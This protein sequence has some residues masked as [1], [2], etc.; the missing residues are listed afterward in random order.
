M[1]SK[2]RR[3]G[4]EIEWVGA[5][6]SMPAY[7]A[8]QGAS[9][10][11]EMLVWMVANGPVVGFAAGKPGTLLA[12]AAG[13][14][15]E[16]M[17]RPSFGPPHRPSRVRVAS[18]ELATV[19]RAGLPPAIAVTCAPTPEID[20][21]LATM[22]EGLSGTGD[23]AP[24]YLSDDVGAD[25][26]AALFR[27]AARLFR[28]SPWSIVPSDQDLFSVTIESLG[29][30]GAALCVI[31]QLGESRALILFSGLDDFE[32]YVAA[33]GAPGGGLPPKLPPH[34]ALNFE[35][36]ADL[37][38]ALRKEIAQHRWEV[39][40]ADGYPWP[41]AVDEDLVPRPLAAGD[42]TIAE[43]LSL[44]LGEALA[45]EAKLRAAWSDG[46]PFARTFRVRTHKGE[47]EVALRTPYEDAPART[48][49]SRELLVRL[50]EIETG[51]EAIDRRNKSKAAPRARRGKR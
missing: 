50:A 3:G 20:L 17:E 40:G 6:A 37:D 48:R 18:P 45:E 5:L 21:V 47:I 29:V 34:F 44:A 46:P 12:D 23:E 26:M 35:R 25:A 38:P 4:H 36:G 51:G 2:K 41:V 16:T 14:A 32:A 39:A 24:S 28:A 1:A 22:R 33:A 7:V 9:Y 43:A 11:P 31:G 30:R 10:R 27:A 49:P 13:H 8:E 19:L 42:V 15:L